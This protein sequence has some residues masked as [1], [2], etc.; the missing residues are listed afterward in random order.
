MNKSDNIKD[1]AAAL[2]KCQ[3]EMGGVVKNSPNPFFKSSY[4]D[5]TAVLQ[6]AKPIWSRNGIAVIQ[7]PHSTD[8]GAGVTTLVM[9][10]SGQWIE[11]EFVLPIVKQDPQAC[12]SAVSYARRYSLAALA[13]L[14]QVDDD[15]ESAMLRESAK[16]PEPV[17]TGERRD[18][19]GKLIMSDEYRRMMINR[20]F[21]YIEAI[22]EGIKAEDDLAVRELLSELTEEEKTAIW[23]APTKFK[24]APFTTAE[25]SYIQNMKRG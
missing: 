2:L 4:A 1:L 10:E 21:P 5:L 3:S 8:R 19:D 20:L 11:H 18:E 9:H 14:P 22:K 25:R 17:Q 12:G 7:H 6:A 15:S 23:V 24:D 13:L 16:K